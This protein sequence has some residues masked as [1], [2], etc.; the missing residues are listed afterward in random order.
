VTPED[1]LVRLA[2]ADVGERIAAFLIDVAILGGV[3]LLM[4]IPLIM[5]VYL[6][7][8]GIGEDV[9]GAIM[10]V[11]FLGHFLL[12]NGYGVYFEW[13]RMGMTPGKK[14]VG[15]QV[16]RPD[17][18]VL[19]LASVLT[20]NFS[21]EVEVFMPL[22]IL[23][24]MRYDS[25]A[26]GSPFLWCLA[27]CLVP[28][29]NRGRRRAGDFAAGTF[30]VKR[31]AWPELPRDLAGKGSPAAN[32]EA[33]VFTTSM[34]EVYGTSQLNALQEV[35]GGGSGRSWGREDLLVE[36]KDKVVNK[37][38]YSDAVADAEARP[39]LLAFYRAMREYLE[40]QLASGRSTLKTLKKSSSS[41][42]KRSRW[43]RFFEPPE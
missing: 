22:K 23:V 24:L 9:A 29:L 7:G 6:T 11:Y 40:G 10:A 21:K 33:Y 18:G 39:F 5:A 28:F 35:L 12:W 42:R 3:S 27:L 30:V 1:F 32:E 4:S 8:Y 14:W 25:F 13:R 38:G 2:P 16:I 31:P 17:A 20:R 19:T 37:I 34:L 41:V 43:A 15:I 26:P 36:I